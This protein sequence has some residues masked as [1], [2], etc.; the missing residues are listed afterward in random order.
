MQIH[1]PSRN[2]IH[3]DTSRLHQQVE[4]LVNPLF[5]PP[6]RSKNLADLYR[7]LSQQLQTSL[8]AE[9]LLEIFFQALSELMPLSGVRYSH[10]ETQ[11]EYQSGKT[12]S[13][14][15]VS[16]RLNH[17]EESLGE[18]MFYHGQR[19]DEQQLNQV[20]TLLRCLLFPLRNALLY[21]RVQQNAL[22]DALTGAGNRV[23]MEQTL[24]RE[25]ELSRRYGQPFSILMFDLDHFKRI[26]DRYGHP[27]GDEALRA[28]V[29]QVQSQLRSVDMLFRFGGEEFLVLLSNTSA[30]AARVVGTHLCDA[31]RRMR[32]M[33][34]HEVH[35]PIS[36]SMGGASYRTPETLQELMSRTDKLLY[37]AKHSGRDQL[38]MAS[39]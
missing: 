24:A 7:Q 35:I 14:H 36:I 29:A 34:E 31:I 15:S 2:T 23:A 5:G 1:S 21:R 9:Q 16:Y 20:E 11:L 13:W 33:N 10:D 6:W 18:L 38:C 39:C 12:D 8:E 32:F 27:C 4:I 37:Q 22:R 28:V 26:N 17:Q 3:F 25:I 30:D 19:F